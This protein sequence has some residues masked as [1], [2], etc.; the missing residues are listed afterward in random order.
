MDTSLFDYDLPSSA[1]AQRA[2]EPRDAARLLVANS[3]ENRLFTDLPSLLDPGD[4]VVVNNTRVR[5]ARV[6]A[7]KETG[8]A[9]EVLLTKRIDEIRWEALVRPARR[10]RP[11]T[12]MRADSLHMTVTT[13]PDRGVVIVEIIPDG[14][15][16]VDD[17]LPEL[18]EVPLPPYFHGTLDDEERYQ[19]MFAR[20]V[21]SAAAPTAAL[22]FTPGIVDALQSRG[23]HIVEVE[24]DVGLDTFRPMAN[25][26][27][28]NHPMHRERYSV[29]SSTVNAI[30]EAKR[31]GSRIVAVGTTVVRTLETAADDKGRLAS[32]SGSTDLFI[33]PGYRTKI[34]DAVV[35]NFHAPR[36]TLI[37]MIAA[38]IG[39]RWRDVYA[40][41]LDSEYRF[42]SFGD[43]M[44]IEV[45]S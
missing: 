37:V 42:L 25:G 39:P 13:E 10:I 36:T 2:I 22:H 16:D 19:T 18:G 23:V 30:D 33:A 24:L 44:F 27:V 35:T 17:I 6:H 32:G 14:H 29:S 8:G 15:D 11:G 34:V 7:T 3:L 41:A 1:I 5:P 28:E 43:A 40:F 26:P 12:T 45:G 20:A 31:N 38:L 21:G 9:V 4:L